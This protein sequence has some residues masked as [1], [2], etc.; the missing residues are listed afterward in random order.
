MVLFLLLDIETSSLE[1]SS[2]EK[3]EIQSPTAIGSEVNPHIS[4][5]SSGAKSFLGTLDVFF[6]A[7]IYLLLLLF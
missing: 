3:D 7:I 4:R 5:S 1:S 2:N 6:L